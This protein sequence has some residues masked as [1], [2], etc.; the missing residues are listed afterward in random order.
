MGGWAGPKEGH[1]PPGHGAA[2][3]LSRCTAT[4]AAADGKLAM[5]TQPRHA[6]PPTCAGH[7][8]RLL[9]SSSVQLR[10]SKEACCWKARTVT[11]PCAGRGREGRQRGGPGRSAADAGGLAFTGRRR[12]QLLSHARVYNKASKRLWQLALHIGKQKLQIWDRGYPTSHAAR[13]QPTHLQ[14]LAKV[15]KYRG[16]GQGVQALDFPRRADVTRL[17][18]RIGTHRQQTGLHVKQDTSS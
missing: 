3:L 13:S 9:P 1:F 8:A 4:Q 18:G 10:C 6:R 11:K 15:A 2:F 12:A 17:Q 14:C 7:Q 16:E 5:S